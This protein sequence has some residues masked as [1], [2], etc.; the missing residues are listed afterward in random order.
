[1]VLTFPK[2]SV[3]C[4]SKLKFS[5]TKMKSICSPFLQK[6][7][8]RVTN[9]SL[10]AGAK[11][12]LR[13]PVGLSRTH[14]IPT[15][16]GRLGLPSPLSGCEA[17]RQTH[18][19]Q[20]WASRAVGWGEKTVNTGRAFKISSPLRSIPDLRKDG[21]VADAVGVEVGSLRWDVVVHIAG[22]HPCGQRAHVVMPRLGGPVVEPQS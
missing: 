3:C 21:G 2:W 1:M 22:L 7:S 16:S 19:G 17:L 18:E 8:A 15:C 10:R 11:P 9:P 13:K 20:V 4:I 12:G 5:S 6:S 14:S